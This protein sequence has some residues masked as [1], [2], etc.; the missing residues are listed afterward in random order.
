[1]CILLD[2]LLF[3][4]SCVHVVNIIPVYRSLH[5]AAEFVCGVC[6]CV[7]GRIFVNGSGLGILDGKTSG[8][9]LTSACSQR[10]LSVYQRL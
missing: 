8:Y 1:M 2:V 5:N 6:V 7:I 10:L 4:V 9:I 3:S